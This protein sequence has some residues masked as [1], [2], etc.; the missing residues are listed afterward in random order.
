MIPVRADL[1][2]YLSNHQTVIL[3]DLVADF[4]C[5]PGPIIAVLD[6]SDD[7]ERV[8]AV[9]NDP[10][11]GF[12]WRLSA[13]ASDPR[14]R[15]LAWRLLRLVEQPPQRRASH[16]LMRAPHPFTGRSVLLSWLKDNPGEW[17]VKQIAEARGVS[18]N[19]LREHMARHSGKLI[20]RRLPIPG[21]PLV[22]SLKPNAY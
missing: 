10:E 18:A 8:P 1:I 16:G 4:M 5:A 3:R 13:L 9:A 19:A 2:R 21:R 7:F 20:K 22:I 14:V 15:D 11:K 17:T 12:R 6:K